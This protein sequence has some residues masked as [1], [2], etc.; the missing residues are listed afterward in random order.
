MDCF[1]GKMA[2]SKAARRTGACQKDKESDGEI[3]DARHLR[4]GRSL[5]PDPSR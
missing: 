5:S 1:E 3:P 4:L 2:A